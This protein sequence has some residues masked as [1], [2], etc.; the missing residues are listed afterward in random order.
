MITYHSENLLDDNAD[1]LVNTV[2]CVGVMGKGLALEFKQR[3]PI[4]FSTYQKSCR[5][6]EVV[7]GRMHIVLENKFHSARDHHRYVVNFPTKR[8]WRENSQL[9]NIEAGLEHLVGF[10]RY[11]ARSRSIA[12]SPLGCGLGGLDWQRDVGPMVLKALQPLPD[13][14]VR[15]YAPE[16]STQE[17]PS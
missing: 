3:H 8:H 1:V 7:P 6:G 16:I 10:I 2:N 11:V 12:L 17:G 15:L 13:V 9:E 4:V 14:D 5:K